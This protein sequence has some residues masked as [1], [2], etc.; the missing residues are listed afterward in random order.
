MREIDFRSDTKTLPSPEMYQAMVR[1][2]LGDD[3]MGEDPTVN[4][5]ESMA[6]EMLGKEA[7]VLVASGTMGN[8]IGV[9]AHCQRGEEVIL[10]SKS[11]IYRGEAGGVSAL[12]GVV[13]QVLPNDDVGR[14]DLAQ[15]EAAIHPADSHYPT[16]RLV[17]LENTA[18]SSGGAPLTPEYMH[19]VQAI[20]KANGLKVHVDGARLFNAAV[21]LETPVDE[22]VK[23]ADTVTFCLSKGLA[24]PVGSVLCGD[25][26]SIERARRLRKMLGAGMRQ[27]GIIAAPGIVALDSMIGRLAEDH[28]NARKLALGLS[29]MPGIEINPDKL[30]TNL[31]FFT[32]TSGDPFEIGR[33]LHGQGILVSAE[34]DVWRWVT[35]YGITSEDIDFALESMAEIM[36]DCAAV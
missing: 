17:A 3:V 28:S 9:L 19:E 8:L 1:A 21:C 18:N 6:A 4:H 31:V 12:G 27:A 29:K 11:H 34:R 25:T 7:A 20:A 35:H 16:T 14:L 33:R 22:L 23:D 24:C 26:E 36:R 32:I 5:L 10:G 30:P 13:M 15:I 2:E